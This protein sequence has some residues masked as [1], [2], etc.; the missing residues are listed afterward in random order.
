[1]YFARHKPTLLDSFSRLLSAWVTV[2]I[3]LLYV[4]QNYENCLIIPIYITLNPPSEV[5][6]IRVRISEKPF[7]KFVYVFGSSF[8]LFSK[9]IMCSIIRSGVS[10]LSLFFRVKLGV[11]LAP[12]L[13]AGTSWPFGV[14]AGI[15]WT[16]AT[17]RQACAFSSRMLRYRMTRQRKLRRFSIQH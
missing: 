2:V 17:H 1:M 13:Q 10:S 6:T 8:N 4:F 15:R 7:Q 5:K 16:V 14:Y 12:F 9:S 11:V 3:Y